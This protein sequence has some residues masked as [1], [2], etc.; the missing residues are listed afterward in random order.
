MKLSRYSS[1]SLNS[2]RETFKSTPDYNYFLEERED[3][4]YEL[5]FGKNEETRKA[6]QKKLNEY[7]TS[8]Q[9]QIAENDQRK[10]RYFFSEH[11]LGWVSRRTVSRLR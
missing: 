8:H 1:N 3:T 5:A 10:V 11:V 9:K 6:I 4:I 2:G 7:R